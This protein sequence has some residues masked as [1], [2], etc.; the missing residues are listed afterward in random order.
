MLTCYNAIGTSYNAIG[1]SYNAF[2]T[3]YNTIGASYNAIGTSYI[4]IGTSYNAI[5]AFMLPHRGSIVQG[6]AHA[7]HLLSYYMHVPEHKHMYV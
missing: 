7:A 6:C 1:T 5:G 3:S 2:G 4:A